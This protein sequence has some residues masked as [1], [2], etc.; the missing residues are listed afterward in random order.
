MSI[1]PIVDYAKSIF[2]DRKINVLEIGA[3]YG[4][5]SKIILKNFNVNKY[6]IVDPYISYPEYKIDGFDKVIANDHDDKIFNNTKNELN[7]IH[8]NVIFHRKFSDDLNTINSIEPNS[9]D[10]IFIDGNHSY[11]YVLADFENY[12]PKLKENGILIKTTYY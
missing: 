8:N 4:E 7:N 2:N 3:C 5:S 12:Y 6:I 11:K 10:F 1:Y 9:I